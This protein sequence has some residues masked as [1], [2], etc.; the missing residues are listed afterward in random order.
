MKET[1]RKLE[2]RLERV[3]DCVDGERKNKRD[4]YEDDSGGRSDTDTRVGR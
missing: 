1:S 4:G 2:V 3:E